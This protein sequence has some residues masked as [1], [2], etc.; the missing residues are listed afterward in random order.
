MIEPLGL[1]YEIIPPKENIPGVVG[2][3][4]NQVYTLSNDAHGFI[5]VYSGVLFTPEYKDYMFETK[6]WEEHFWYD[7]RTDKEFKKLTLGNAK[8]KTDI[9]I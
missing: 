7:M 2:F 3:V 4:Q 6:K 9:I 5:V 8:G 1:S